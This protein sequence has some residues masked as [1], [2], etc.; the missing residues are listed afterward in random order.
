MRS[1]RPSRKNALLAAVAACLLAGVAACGAEPPE[2]QRTVSPATLI[3]GLPAAA[4][5]LER[6]AV[7]FDHAAHTAALG[8]KNCTTCHEPDEHSGLRVMLMAAGEGDRDALTEAYHGR[9]IGCHAE[10]AGEGQ[11]TGPQACGACH[12]RRAAPASL[13]VPMGFDLSLHY[14]HVRAMDDKCDACHHVYDEARKELVYQK[15]AEGACRDCHGDATDGKKLSLRLASHTSC[16]GCHLARDGEGKESGPRLCTGC[17]GSTEQAAIEKVADVPRLKRGQPDQVWLHA[18]GVTSDL[19]AFDHAG[20]EK[21]TDTC[22]ACHH[23]T[24]RACK[25]CH[26]VAGQPEGA[27]VTLAVA[28]HLATSE[29][30]CAGCHDRKAEAT[31]C[32]G[33]HHTLP[34]PPSERSCAACHNGPRPPAEGVEP[35]GA[36]PAAA[37]L[38]ALPPASDDFPDEVVIEGL[39]KD[40]GAAKLPHRRIVVALDAAV[41]ESKLAERFHGRTETLC[42][43]CHHRSPVGTRPAACG[44]C[45]GE[46]GAAA[47]D[48]PGLKVAYH[49]QCMGCHQQMN[50]DAQGCTSCHEKTEVQP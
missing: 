48:Q 46:K 2:E 34:S 19:V 25:E 23:K 13:R 31:G 37:Q 1:S 27:G 41:R 40:Y 43:G 36:F 4:G 32:A 16:V 44:A 28:Q 45:H 22:S 9:C 14:R 21:A 24:L 47:R 49:R 10:R 35:Q 8:E 50:I 18:A 20:H 29:H 26:T 5:P 7:E 42:A 38:A 39:A 3:L 30:S 12:V 33:C 6:P 15:E 17:H 11:P